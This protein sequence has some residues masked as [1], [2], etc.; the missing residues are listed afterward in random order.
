MN[1]ACIQ[2]LKDT[3]NV[4]EKRNGSSTR[5]RQ[6]PTII[7]YLLAGTGRIPRREFFASVIG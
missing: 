5:N 7:R 2:P 3:K 4:V 6:S 1:E